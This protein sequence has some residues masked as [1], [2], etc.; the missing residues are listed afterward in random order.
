MVAEVYMRTVGEQTGWR[1]TANRAAG[2]AFNYSNATRSSAVIKYFSI[3]ES[4]VQAAEL[5]WQL[6]L[7]TL[8]DCAPMHLACSWTSH[9]RVSH[10]THTIWLSK[11]DC[12]LS[13][14]SLAR[15]A[16]QASTRASNPCTCV[17]TPQRPSALQELCLLIPL[18]ASLYP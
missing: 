6:L 17:A 10:G 1:R 11:T 15:A 3:V 2:I 8:P 12:H 18:Q 14:A 7:V 13:T 4:V 9:C 16:F 5:S